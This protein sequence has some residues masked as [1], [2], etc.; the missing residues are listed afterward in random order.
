MSFVKASPGN[1]VPAHVHNTNETFM[2]LEGRWR[3]FWEGDEGT[4]SVDLGRYDL[5]SIP[6]HVMRRF[7]N[8]EAGSG[9]AQ[10]VLLG[11]IAGDNPTAEYSREAIEFLVEH[12]R[13]PLEQLRELEQR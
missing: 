7:E 12:G 6:P 1:G 8:L 13:V 11:V 10:G 2:V 3:I 9:D 4:E 5:I